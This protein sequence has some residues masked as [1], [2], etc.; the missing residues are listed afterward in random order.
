MTTELETTAITL[1]LTWYSTLMWGAIGGAAFDALEFIRDVRKGVGALPVQWKK[2]AMYVALLIRVAFGALVALLMVST[3]Q[4][5]GPFGAFTVGLTMP[6]VL[7]NLIRDAQTEPTSE[8]ATADPT[9]DRDKA[10]SSTYDSINNGSG[11]PPSS[12]PSN[13]MR[14]AADD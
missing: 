7:Q 14:D 13:S 9:G 8:D 4:V 5:T 6:L 3:E 12:S 1:T 11:V 2:P 10:K